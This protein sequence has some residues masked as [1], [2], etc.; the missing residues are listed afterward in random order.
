[1]R[2]ESRSFSLNLS[3]FH[4]VTA[5]AFTVQVCDR[6]LNV[7]LDAGVSCDVSERRI[8]GAVGGDCFGMRQKPI[9]K[10]Q[11]ETLVRPERP[12]RSCRPR[13]ND[14]HRAERVVRYLLGHAALQPDAE[15]LPRSADYDDH[16][17]APRR[18][19]VHNGRRHHRPRRFNHHAIGRDQCPAERAARVAGEHV[20]VGA[21]APGRANWRI[22]RTQSCRSAAL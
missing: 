7:R 15:P 8:E 17:G 10:E 19:G 4:L 21:E 16:L 18:S 22:R 1:L 12:G 3:R 11:C 9:S 6:I 13:S 5:L 14:E 2:D 20:V